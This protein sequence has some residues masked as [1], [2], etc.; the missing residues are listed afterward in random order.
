MEG[1]EVYLRGPEEMDAAFPDHEEAVRRAQEIADSV[2]ISL[3]LGKR[4]FPAYKLPAEK[5]ADEYL[6]ELCLSGLHERYSGNEHMC[7][8]GE[9]ASHVMDRLNRELGVINKL[10]FSNYFLICWDFVRYARQQG[11]PATARG[12]GVGAIVCYALYLSH[13]FPI[14]YDL[15]F[16][17]FLDENRKEAPDIDIDFCKER[18]SEIM[19]Y[20]KEKYGEENVAQIGTFGTFGT[21]GSVGFN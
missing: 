21:F 12:S 9:L 1:K 19:R 8:G 7:P 3:D 16:E 17:R 18:R 13:V 2:D 11:V 5:N 6:R 14:A 15:L 4:H 10:G 20:V